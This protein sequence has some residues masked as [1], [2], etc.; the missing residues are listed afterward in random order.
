MISS[1]LIPL[2]LKLLEFQCLNKW[3]DK[4][5]FKTMDFNSNPS[6]FQAPCFREARPVISIRA[7]CLHC[8]VVYYHNY[9]STCLITPI[10]PNNNTNICQTNTLP[11][12]VF[13]I[14][15]ITWLGCQAKIL[16]NLEWMLVLCLTPWTYN[17]QTIIVICI[18]SI[19][20]RRY[21]ALHHRR[22]P[23]TPGLSVRWPEVIHSNQ[24]MPLQWTFC[25]KLV[26][27]AW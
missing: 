8:K 9:R 7:V 12:L 1:T 19:Y 3:Q 14:P 13:Q 2:T 10:N 25:S 5:S 23:S 20:C 26:H 6:S 18:C 11:Q 21:S 24:I 27:Q 22:M 17:F 4:T 16:F 15:W